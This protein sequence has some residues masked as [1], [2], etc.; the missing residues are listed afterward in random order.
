MSRMELRVFVHHNPRKHWHV[1]WVEEGSRAITEWE[2]CTGYSTEAQARQAA[3]EELE[4][5]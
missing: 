3:R 4:E 1:Q 5:R 2:G